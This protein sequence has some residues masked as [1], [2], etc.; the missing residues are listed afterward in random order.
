AVKVGQVVRFDGRKTTYAASSRSSSNTRARKPPPP[1]PPP[2]VTRKKQNRHDE[3]PPD[4]EKV[5]TRRAR[6]AG[7]D[8]DA[9]R[10]VVG[11]LCEEL[12]RIKDSLELFVRSERGQTS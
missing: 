4:Q 6:L 10:S 11:A 3:G 12:V 7:P 5:E 8:R 2:S 9:M 1:P